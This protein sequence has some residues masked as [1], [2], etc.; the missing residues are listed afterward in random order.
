MRL[1]VIVVVVGG[2]ELYGE[3]G[4]FL[5]YLRGEVLSGRGR[6]AWRY[7]VMLTI[8]GVFWSPAPGFA[9]R[10]K[11]QVCQGRTEVKPLL[12]RRKASGTSKVDARTSLKSTW[13]AA[14]SRALRVRVEFF[15][16]LQ[17][18]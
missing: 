8:R 14:L 18:A 15:I 7:G 2:E 9:P 4:R 13:W 1:V 3:L 6:V 12:D 10:A 11:C 16:R 17:S 5:K